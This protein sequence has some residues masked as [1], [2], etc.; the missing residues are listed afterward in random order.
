MPFKDDIKRKVPLR[1]Q[2]TPEFTT[3]LAIVAKR[4]FANS[5]AL[6]MFLDIE[7]ATCQA[8]LNANKN[9]S[10]GNRQRSRCAK[11]L[12]FFRTVK[13]KLLPYLV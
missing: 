10:S 11:H 1:Y 8:W 4:N 13:E 2:N 7:M 3:F 12:A 9:T 5:R 6:R